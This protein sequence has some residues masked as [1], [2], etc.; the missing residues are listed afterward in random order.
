MIWLILFF[1]VLLGIGLFDYFRTRNFDEFVVAGRKQSQA[2][3]MMSILATAL[4][5][6]ATLG[7]VNF[8]YKTGFP[9]IWWL[10]GGALGLVLQALFLSEKV[11][12]FDGYTLPHIAQIVAGEAGKIIMAVIIVIAWV[13]IIAAQ[14]VAL[15]KIIALLTGK[16]DSTALLV[17]TSLVVII[18]TVIGGQ[19]S[20]LKTDAL[21]FLLLVS[22][23]AYTFYYLFF[24]GGGAGIDTSA[25]LSS[26]R[27]LGPGFDVLQLLYFLLIVGGSYF[28]GPDIFSRNFTAKDGATAKKAT[29]KAGF[30]LLGAAL[31]ITFTGMWARQFAGDI[32]QANVFVHL[33]SFH[34]PRWAGVLLSLGLLSAI[35]SSADTCIITSAAIIENDIL[36]KKKILDTRLIALLS[37]LIALIIA[38]FINDIIAL[39]LQAYSVFTPG[40]VCPLFIAIIYYKKRPLNKHLWLAAI[41][42]GGSLGLLSTILGYRPLALAG[43]ALSLLISLASVQRKQAGQ[44]GKNHAKTI[45]SISI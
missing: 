33:I 6:S 31:L 1:L 40:I 19:R 11:R 45:K 26:T 43:M 9:A 37:G 4:G 14:F 35:I 24:G 5:A 29:M 18:Y 7:V 2:L 3:V 36:R 17:F 39:L 8:A 12:S 42:A 25:V 21:Q 27:L 15:S 41:I 44:S 38:V 34:L 20:I 32:G 28:I 13:G 22:G 16:T 23:L 10:G 30:I